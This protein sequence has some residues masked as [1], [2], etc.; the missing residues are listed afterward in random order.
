[1]LRLLNART[2]QLVDLRAIADREQSEFV[3]KNNNTG[4]GKE[5]S[6]DCIK[7]AVSRSTLRKSS[8]QVVR[9]E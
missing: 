2:Y 6:N 8:S 9:D 5:R 7:Y 3:E 1:V 4:V